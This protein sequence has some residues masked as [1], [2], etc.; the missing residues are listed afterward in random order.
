MI[1]KQPVVAQAFNVEGNAEGFELIHKERFSAR[2][3]QMIGREGSKLACAVR[4][5]GTILRTSDNDIR[6]DDDAAILAMERNTRQERRA[7]QR[8]NLSP[9]RMFRSRQSVINDEAELETSKTTKFNLPDDDVAEDR[10]GEANTAGGSAI[11]SRFTFR[12]V[13]DVCCSAYADYD[14]GDDNPKKKS[15]SS[16]NGDGST[17]LTADSSKVSDDIVAQEPKTTNTATAQ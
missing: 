2:L 13:D 10:D 9:G 12:S 16:I 4:P 15:G 3:V 7:S 17:A 14:Y 8:R 1:S 11:M 6:E 5:L